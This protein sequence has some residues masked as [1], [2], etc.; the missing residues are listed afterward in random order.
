MKFKSDLNF[1]QNS[2]AWQ[3]HYSITPH[4]DYDSLNSDE[5]S[6]LRLLND[7][8]R[9]LEEKYSPIIDAKVCELQERVADTSGWMMDFNLDFVLT[10]YLREDDPEYEES[11]DNILMVFDELFSIRNDRL[12]HEWGFGR[13]NVNH[14]ESKQSFEGEHHCYIYHQLY[15][16]CYLDWR[17]LLRIGRLY[18]DIKIEEQSGML[19]VAR[20]HNK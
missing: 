3:G 5:K 12:D 16:H 11:D 7:Q 9:Q 2:R 14:A 17:D 15:D 10:Y 19:P 1:F 4:T 18:V 6:W 13:T 8:L 20:L